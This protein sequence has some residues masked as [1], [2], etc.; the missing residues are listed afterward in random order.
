VAGLASC[1]ASSVSARQPIPA[2]IGQAGPRSRFHRP[3]ATA[4]SHQPSAVGT[5]R[6][7]LDLLTAG[8]AEPKLTYDAHLA[9]GSS[10]QAVMGGLAMMF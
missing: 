7:G 4:A 5:L 8:G 3:A 2:A 1:A 10:A 9:P 6:A